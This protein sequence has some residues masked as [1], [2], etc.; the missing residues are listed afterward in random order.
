M[1]KSIQST[2]QTILNL[3]EKAEDARAVSLKN[4]KVSLANEKEKLEE[5]EK[6]KSSLLNKTGNRS[7]DKVIISL[8]QLQ[9]SVDYQTQ[10]NESIVNQTCEVD[11]ALRKMEKDQSNLTNAS[12]D[13]KVVEKLLDRK[14]VEFL[15]NNRRKESK[16]ESEIALK[17][18]A[19]KT[20]IWAD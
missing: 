10:L 16:N 20:K 7:R 8:N 11:N 6:K 1:P 4:T 19:G 12:K 5:I 18:T 13:K 2:I 3:R 17:V 9:V 15:K 14:R